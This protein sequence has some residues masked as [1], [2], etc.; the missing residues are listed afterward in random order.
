MGSLHTGGGTQEHIIT[1][2]GTRSYKPTLTLPISVIKT[3]LPVLSTDLR[4]N[5]IDTII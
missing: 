1:A 2:H 4:S 5:A 3:N